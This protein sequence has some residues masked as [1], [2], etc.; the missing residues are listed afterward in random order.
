MDT[1]HLIRDLEYALSSLSANTGQLDD[2]QRHQVLQSCRTLCAAVET[3]VNRFVTWLDLQTEVRHFPFG[4]FLFI[5]GPFPS[6]GQD[7]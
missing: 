6:A 1:H 7:S 4:A 2:Q 3:P 5:L